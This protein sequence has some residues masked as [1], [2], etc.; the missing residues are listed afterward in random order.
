M[1]RWMH[2]DK[3]DFHNGFSIMGTKRI[4]DAWNDDRKFYTIF[5]L[6]IVFLFIFNISYAVQSKKKFTVGY[7]G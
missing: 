6:I 7:G 5:L 3:G 1:Q 2:K 4:L